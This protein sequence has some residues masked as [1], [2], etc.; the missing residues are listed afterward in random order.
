[1]ENYHFTV[2]QRIRFGINYICEHFHIYFHQFV[3]MIRNNGSKSDLI[4][5]IYY[6]FSIQKL[7]NYL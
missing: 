7:K 2:K 5:K 4:G 6:I 3:F 1:M